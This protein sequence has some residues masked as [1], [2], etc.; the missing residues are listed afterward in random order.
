[1]VDVAMDV[2]EVASWTPLPCPYPTSNLVWPTTQTGQSGILN[3][4]PQQAYAMTY[5]STIASII[6]YAPTDISTTIIP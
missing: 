3:P 6:G 4:R 2:V 1:M 5:S